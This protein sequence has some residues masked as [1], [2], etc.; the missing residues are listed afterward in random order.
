MVN[1]TCS[2]SSYG[3]IHNISFPFRLKTNPEKL[4]QLQLWTVVWEQSHGAILSW[5]LQLRYMIYQLSLTFHKDRE[6]YIPTKKKNDVCGCLLWFCTLQYYFETCSWRNFQYSSIIHALF[7][8][9]SIKSPPFTTTHIKKK[10]IYIY[11]K[12]KLGRSGG[13]SAPSRP[14]LTPPLAVAGNQK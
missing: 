5:S 7:I 6:I 9:I 8:T 11:I 14:P 12:K 13:A 1:H 10:Y 4:Q 3:N 2:A